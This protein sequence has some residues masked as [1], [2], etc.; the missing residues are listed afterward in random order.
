MIEND[1]EWAR[2]SAW[3]TAALETAPGF[4]TIED[5]ER[6]IASTEYQFWPGRNCA[7]VTY[8]TNYE[9]RKVLT[10]THGGGDL[11][12]L[13]NELEPVMCKWAVMNGCDGV[14]GEGRWGWKPVCEKRGYRLA[15]I[16]MIKDLA[17][18]GEVS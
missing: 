2:C 6:K 7:A 3:I 4:E 14:A 13:L 12:E 8:I 10:V 17:G 15:H 5:V 11:G 18:E 16:T 1:K 9:R